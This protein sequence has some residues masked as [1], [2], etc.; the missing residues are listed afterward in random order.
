MEVLDAVYLEDGKWRFA[1]VDP[2]FG[3]SVEDLGARL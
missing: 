3:F 1:L 2:G